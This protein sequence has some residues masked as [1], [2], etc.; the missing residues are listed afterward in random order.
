MHKRFR[1]KPI[2]LLI[3]QSLAITYA[4]ADDTAAPPAPASG[5][6]EVVTIFGTGQTR[7][8][9]NVTRD[10]L[11]KVVPGTSPL[12]TLE[13]LPGVSF[14]SADPFG[15]YEWSTRFSIRGFSQNQLGFTL[16]NV[17]LG[18]MS[19][20]AN[21]GL[22]ISRAISSENIGR[23][24]VSQGAGTLATASTSNLGGTVQFVTLDPSDERGATL[25]QTIGSDSTSRTFVRFD[26][27]MFDTGTKF[28]LSGTRQRADKSKGWGAQNQDQINAKLVQKFGDSRLSM[29]INTSERHEVDYADMALEMVGRLG[30]NWD[31]YAPDWQR[32]V[33]AAKGLYSGGVTNMDDAYYLGRGLRKDTLGGATLNLVLSEAA[34]LKTTVYHHD[35]KGM[36][37]WYTPYQASPSGVPIS[38][39]ATEYTIDR[40]GAVVD[41]SYDIG[42]HT[43][44]AGAWGEKSDHGLTRNFYGINGPEDM[45]R[46]LS[47]PF[48][49][50]FKQDFTT[51]TS[52]FY[53]AD[54]VTLM[55]GDM[56]VNAGFKAPKT[57]IVAKNIVA[58]RAEGEITASKSFLPQVGVNY[59]LSKNDEVFVS[60]SQNMRAYQ[61]GVNGPFSTSQ[62]AFDGSA[63]NLKPETSTTVDLGFR[64]KRE[65][66][67]GSVSL[68]HADFKDRLLNVAS[69]PGIA[70]CP[71]T[72]I[73]VGKVETQGI[74]T[75]AVLK[76]AP[77]W[78]WFNS[79]TYNDSKYKADYFDNGYTNPALASS[80]PQ[81]HVVRASGKQVVDTAKML[82]NT[83]LSYENP[84][85]FARGGAKFTDKRYYTYLNDVEV[86]AFWV[87]T[88]SAGYK[89]KSLGLLKDASLQLNVTN[90]FN[91]QYFS[92]VGTNGFLTADPQGAYAT[93]LSGA[94]RQVFVSLNA[95][96]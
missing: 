70:G 45:D 74:E 59:S 71:S 46:F 52:Q 6:I 13:K 78:S 54:T 66:L 26:T 5:K 25:A 48:K 82:F 62:A 7:Q 87:A 89:I 14:Q 3:L 28:Y 9:Q 22:H 29:F 40:N 69:C 53:V 8:V 60:A 33:N 92:T 42:N 63:A 67:Q 76:L 27:G 10:D 24:A 91:K 73:N 72:F 57:H 80:D 39:R 83:E 65:M 77:E 50:A 85:W 90:L 86:P 32:A 96:I 38:I 49:T 37:Q 88:F 4:Y 30:Y 44:S 95:K 11:I 43:L 1:L 16:D 31:N 19:Y 56:K 23:V 61:P 64:F 41:W 93:L 58:G 15:A 36:G 81:S 34:T 35:N 84:V 17:P 68:Y 20:S 47:D 75:A 21:N 55:D 2:Y 18:D 79:F 94:P 12:K 51:T